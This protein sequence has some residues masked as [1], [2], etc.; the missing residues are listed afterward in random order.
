M[1]GSDDILAGSNYFLLKMKSQLNLN[2]E[3]DDL[4]AG[5]HDLLIGSNDLF[6]GSD[7]PFGENQVY[8]YNNNAGHTKIAFWQVSLSE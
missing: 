4:T 5:C 7:H 2:T 6:T 1:A 3:S 8:L